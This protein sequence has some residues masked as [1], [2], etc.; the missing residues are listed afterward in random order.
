[1]YYEVVYIKIQSITEWI[2][3]R[4]RE[5]GGEAGELCLRAVWAG[6]KNR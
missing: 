4:M 6:A 1:M 5:L 2:R 3:I